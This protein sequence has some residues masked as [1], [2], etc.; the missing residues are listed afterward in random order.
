MAIRAD[1][2]PTA[3]QND[4]VPT[5]ICDGSEPTAIWN[6][7]SRRAIRDDP[8]PAEIW[9]GVELTLLT[10]VRADTA[11]TASQDNAVP[12]APNSPL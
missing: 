11:P 1:T 12:T 8:A 5:A 9:D 4:A 6:D 2:A 3:S 10:A 7:I